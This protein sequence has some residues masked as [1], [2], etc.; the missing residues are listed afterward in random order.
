MKFLSFFKLKFKFFCPHAIEEAWQRLTH[1]TVKHSLASLTMEQVLDDL[2][3]DAKSYAGELAPYKF[4]LTP[5]TRGTFF[6]G[7]DMS[8]ICGDM[9]SYMSGCVVRVD[10]RP[11]FTE[12]LG[13]S[14]PIV[15][16]TVVTYLFVTGLVEHPIVLYL[17][18]AGP[19]VGS[20]GGWWWTWRGAKKS[21]YKLL[22]GKELMVP[23]E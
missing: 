9:N 7:R 18:L 19:F 6:R 2:Q 10:V 16:S 5:L 23:M 11:K 20:F 12:V 1:V 21:L 14:I 17:L 22:D 3:S 4:R 15:M 8:L 13:M